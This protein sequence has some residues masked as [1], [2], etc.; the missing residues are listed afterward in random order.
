MRRIRSIIIISVLGLLVLG[1][2]V[3][4]WLGVTSEKQPEVTNNEKQPESDAVASR[5][6]Y[7][8]DYRGYIAEHARTAEAG[9][10]EVPTYAEDELVMRN[11]TRFFLG[12]D[13]GFYKDTSVRF[14]LFRGVLAWFPSTALRESADGS[15]IYVMYDTDL[16]GRLYLF[17]SKARD[18]LFVDG[19][20]VLMRNR[21]SHQDFAG[22]KVG[23]SIKAVIG[24]DSVTD[25]Y[26]GMFDTG[27]DI[28]IEN[29]IKMG[30]PPTTIHLL[31]D[32]ILKIE[33]RRD[34]DKDYTVTDL[35]WSPDFV[36]DGFEGQTCYRI[37]ELDYV[38]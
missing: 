31:S 24:I 9:A 26:R 37:E 35:T 12:R 19:F 11:G 5:M 10:L 34:A 4:Y 30:A 29:Y 25:I 8:E 16:G 17:F 3:A 20:P 27:N 38:K 15:Y 36:L 21:L 13:S 1:G 32:G 33:Y 28:V 2:G 6:M 7:L 18:Y 22:I 14:D 23:D